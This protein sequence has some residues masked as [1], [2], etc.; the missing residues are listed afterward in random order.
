MS[1][2]NSENF[3]KDTNAPAATPPM[4]MPPMAANTAAPGHILT[5]KMLFYLQGS[6]PWLRFVSVTGFISLGISLICIL[7]MAGSDSFDELGLDS[8]SSL[9]VFVSTLPFLV[10][11]FSVCFFPCNSVTK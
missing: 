1:D 8:G 5:E 2:Y 4:A 6:A 10:I 3:P 7:V 11:G 9:L